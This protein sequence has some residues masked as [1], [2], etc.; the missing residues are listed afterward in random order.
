MR[1][2]P[3]PPAAVRTLIKFILIAVVS[4]F[5][6]GPV[7]FLYA[8]GILIVYWMIGGFVA[9]LDPKTFAKSDIPPDSK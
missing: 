6:F 5:L 8:L 9:L 7:G 3:K 4:C 2:F 1:W